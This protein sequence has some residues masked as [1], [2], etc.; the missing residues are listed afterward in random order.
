M[1]TWHTR[2]YNFVTTATRK[3]YESTLNWIASKEDPD[4]IFSYYTKQQV[5]FLDWKLGAT[6]WSIQVTMAVVIIGYCLFYSE[7]YLAFEQAKGAVIT[8]V[9]GDAVATSIGKPGTR[10]FS[11]E[12][13]TFPGLE[14]GNV[15]IAT[16]QTVH[17][18]MRGVCEDP[19]MPCNSDADCL[20]HG[21]KGTCTAAGLC[22]VHSWCNVED[23][24]EIY[25]MQVD[26]AQIWVR[27]FIQFVKLAPEEMFTTDS[28][29][30]EP[31]GDNT[32]TIRQLLEMVD[33]MPVHYE[34]VAQLGGVFEVGIRWICNIDSVRICRPKLS[35]RRLDSILDPDD[36]GYGFS[37]AEYIDGDHR[38]QNDVK[39]LRFLFRTNGLGKQFSV[40]AAI[41]TVSTSGTLMSLALV[42][43]D[44]LL[45]KV[46]KNRDKFIAR[47]YEKTPDFSEYMKVVDERKKGA[48]VLA[49]IEKAEQLVMDKEDQWM[50]R[51]EERTG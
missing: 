1:P 12:E 11:T 4:R 49:D 28:N 31:D 41:T 3:N 36:I 19:D 24:P 39:G 50:K 18:Q 5:V 20:V 46:F 7:G 30:S 6:F 45:T 17:R 25:E 23:K 38:L 35:V 14:N 51:F 37:H 10:F 27:S 44:L 40:M 33:P 48:T 34:E 2:L 15:F 16:R 13:L 29:S 8:H 22:S 21:A 47:K 32:F 42:I 9:A 26:L 43:A